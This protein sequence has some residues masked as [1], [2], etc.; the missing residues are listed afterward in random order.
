MDLV[1]QLLNLKLI[2]LWV[3]Y[4][5]NNIVSE[6][7]LQGGNKIN[8]IRG[9]KNLKLLKIIIFPLIHP[10]NSIEKLSS[11]QLR[12]RDYI[13]LNKNNN[14]AKFLMIIPIFI[15]FIFLNKINKT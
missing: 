10:S 15:T 3:L 13:L 14:R 2:L 7:T 5:Y 11:T 12:E 8:E 1:L 9:K 6:E 4:N